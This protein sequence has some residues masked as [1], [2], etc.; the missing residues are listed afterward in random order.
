ML[1]EITPVYEDLSSENSLQRCIGGFTQNNNETLNA[2]IWSFAPKRV[3]S[4][5]K[6]VKIA[7]YLAE[8][9]F[10]EGY[11][12]ILKMMHIYGPNSVALCT[13]VDDITISIATARSFE[14]KVIAS[15]LIDSNFWLYV[16][17]ILEVLK[18]KIV[19]TEEENLNKKRC[20]SGFPYCFLTDFTKFFL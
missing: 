4:G 1:S 3:F 15:N 17:S 13:E 18:E 20:E 11:E 16:Q 5:A 14:A 9:I 19:I 7:S 10:N 8:S 6:T 12:S 2:L